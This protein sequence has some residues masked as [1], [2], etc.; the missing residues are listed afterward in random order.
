[1][2]KIQLLYFNL[3]NDLRSSDS[4]CVVLARRVQEYI[5]FD[6]IKPKVL[7]CMH[8]HHMGT[9][10]EKIEKS[11][12]PS[13]NPDT[14]TRNLNEAEQRSWYEPRR[15]KKKHLHMQNQEKELSYS[16][17][18]SPKPIPK[19]DLHNCCIRIW[20]LIYYNFGSRNC[21]SLTSTSILLIQ[22]IKQSI[23]LQH[24][25]TTKGQ[26]CSIP[27]LRLGMQLVECLMVQMTI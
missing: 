5:C 7:K 26:D 21:I 2:I 12:N 20:V 19:S 16:I 8:L 15:T 6:D 17:K 22:V 13:K 4:K 11:S 18:K 23:F 14:C 9:Y 10:Q 24:K 1:M 27:L 25:S 3:T